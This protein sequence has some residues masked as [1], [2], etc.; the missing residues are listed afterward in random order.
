[1]Q[2]YRCH[3]RGMCRKV[4]DQLL[5]RRVGMRFH[6]AT[7]MVGLAVVVILAAVLP[8]Q[9]EAL[10]EL[11]DFCWTLDAPGGPII[12][13]LR[14]SVNQMTSNPMANPPTPGPLFQV[15]VR[16]RA[17]TPMLGQLTVGDGTVPYELLGAGTVGAPLT[18]MGSFNLGFHAALIQTVPTS[19]GGNIGC[20]FAAVLNQAFSGPWRVQCSGAPPPAPPFSATGQLRFTPC[21]QAQ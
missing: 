3:S 17:P 6:V 15:Q 16:W 2:T 9:A 13:T 10:T 7:G 18:C 5:K 1:M 12:D 11:G 14:L 4:V 19:F 8:S 21:T 20:S